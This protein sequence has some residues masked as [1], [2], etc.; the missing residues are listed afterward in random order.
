LIILNWYLVKFHLHP[1]AICSQK[2][3]IKGEFIGFYFVSLFTIDKLALVSIVY[4]EKKQYNNRN[5]LWS[6]LFWWVSCT[7][8]QAQTISTAEMAASDGYSKRFTDSSSSLKLQMA[9]LQT[10]QETG[11]K[12]DEAICSAYLALTHKRLLHFKEFMKYAERSYDIAGSVKSNRAKAFSSWAMGS[13]KSYIDDK[14]QA[15]HFFLEAYTLFS[16]EGL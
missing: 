7:S 3:Y 16:D 5:S 15:L 12:E 2:L 6:L 8:L 1:V 11:N 13:L 14:S 9:A 4:S 10:A